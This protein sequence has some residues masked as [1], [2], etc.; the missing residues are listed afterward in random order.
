MVFPSARFYNVGHF[1]VNVK[2]CIERRLLQL[3]KITTTSFFLV[4]FLGSHVVTYCSHP[5]SDR[6]YKFEQY[7]KKTMH[8]GQQ[9]NFYRIAGN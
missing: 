6:Y 5:D 4:L 9:L 8:H 3:V 7:V 2:W 1:F